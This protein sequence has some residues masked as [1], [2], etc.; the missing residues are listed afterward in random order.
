LAAR[1]AAAQARATGAVLLLQVR[2]EQGHPLT[3]AQVAVGGVRRVG[4]SDAGGQVLL[5]AIPAGNRLVDVRRPGYGMVRVAADFAAAD[6]VRR[7]VVMTPDPIEL[8]GIVATSWGRSMRLHRAGYY[9]RQRRGLGAYMGR[10]RLDQIRPARTVDAF[11][12][13]RGFK[14][15]PRGLQ[16]IVVDTRGGDCL[17]KVYIDGTKM[18]VISARDQAQALNM[19]SPDDIEAIEAYLGPTIPVEYN[20]VGSVC[21][22]ILIWTRAGD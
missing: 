22:V 15:L 7:E 18:F 17:P 2:D 21:G 5:D 12:H 11:R 8:D 16:Q 9:E 10:E 6:T 20:P 1:T 13:M 19:V 3:G 4:R 14:V